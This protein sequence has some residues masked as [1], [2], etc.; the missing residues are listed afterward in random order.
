MWALRCQNGVSPALPT[1]HVTLYHRLLLFIP[2]RRDFPDGTLPGVILHTTHT[3]H[4]GPFILDS[5]STCVERGW[6]TLLS[7]PPPSHH[8]TVHS[9]SVISLPAIYHTF[10]YTVPDV[11]QD[12]PAILPLF[13]QP[14]DILD[15]ELRCH[16]V[17]LWSQVWVNT[18][19]TWS[20]VG[21]TFPCSDCLSRLSST[22]ACYTFARRS[23]PARLHHHLHVAFLCLPF[24]W[25]GDYLIPLPFLGAY[26]TITHRTSARNGALLH[27]LAREHGGATCDISTHPFGLPPWSLYTDFAVYLPLSFRHT[28]DLSQNFVVP[29]DLCLPLHLRFVRWCVGGGPC[30]ILRSFLPF[31]G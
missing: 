23:V 20:T 10:L 21:G 31:I 13:L 11:V 14:T 8:H 3:L 2:P 1:S 7:T 15:T 16:G 28:T 18:T 27:E 29:V 24:T 4:F 19:T 6:N 22:T 5:R 12:G 25:V 30:N 9:T 17:T 26:H